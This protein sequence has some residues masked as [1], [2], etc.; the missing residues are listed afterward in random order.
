MLVLRDIP[1]PPERPIVGMEQVVV[2]PLVQTFEQRVWIERQLRLPMRQLLERL[3]EHAFAPRVLLAAEALRQVVIFQVE[4][5]G[6][7]E[8]QLERPAVIDPLAPVV[9]R[10]LAHVH[11]AQMGRA[12]GREPVLRRAGVGAADG[13]DVAVAPRLRGDPL[14]SVVAV[15]VNTPAIV[16]KRNEFSVGLEAPAHILNDDAVA[17]RREE[18]RRPDLDLH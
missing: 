4:R 1:L 10:R 15:A 2:V 13:A 9:R 16:V 18:R 14:N 12:R 8:S 5:P 17:A 3:F 11:G 6:V 7:H